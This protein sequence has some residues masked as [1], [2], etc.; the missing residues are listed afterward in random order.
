ML[1]I[2]HRGLFPQYPG[3]IESDIMAYYQY[4]AVF[5]HHF[6]NVPQDIV[7]VYQVIEHLYNTNKVEEF[8]F[9]KSGLE[10]IVNN[11]P[12]H[13][14]VCLINGDRKST[15]LNSSHSQIS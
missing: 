15:R 12:F 4:V 5:F 7:G 6:A 1:Y 2:V 13:V 10:N 11:V 14:L 9:V 3:Q 8:L